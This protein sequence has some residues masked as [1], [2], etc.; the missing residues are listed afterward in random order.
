MIPISGPKSTLT[1]KDGFLAFSFFLTSK[2]VPIFNYT[3]KKSTGQLE[4][5]HEIKIAKKNIARLK[6]Q[7]S[8]IKGE[9]NA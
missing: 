6:T 5:T 8:Q 2:I 1:T 9:E 3:F 7:M 4:K